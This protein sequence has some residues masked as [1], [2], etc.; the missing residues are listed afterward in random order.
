MLAKPAAHL[1]VLHLQLPAMTR[2][3]ALVALTMGGNDLLGAYG[4]NG[5]DANAAQSAVGRI[6][7]VGEAVLVQLH[8]FAGD[9]CRI[10]VTTIYDPPTVPVRCTPSRRHRGRKACSSSPSRTPC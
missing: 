2:P 5:P 10:I 6:A 4:V 8:R 9:D 3:P 7:A 1:D